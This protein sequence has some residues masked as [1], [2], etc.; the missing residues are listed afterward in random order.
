MD[1]LNSIQTST[2]DMDTKQLKKEFGLDLCHVYQADVPPKNFMVM[3]E[4]VQKYGKYSQDRTKF[5]YS[6]GSD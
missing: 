2:K 1:A 5:A 3:W 6:A 4:A